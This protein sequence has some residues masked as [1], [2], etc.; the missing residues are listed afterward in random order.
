MDLQRQRVIS[1]IAADQAACGP[2]GTTIGLDS[3]IDGSD[4]APGDLVDLVTEHLVW[5]GS[6]QERAIAMYQ[7]ITCA[8]DAAR[9]RLEPEGD[10]IEELSLQRLLTAAH[11]HWERMAGA[12]GAEPPRVDEAGSTGCHRLGIPE[13]LERAT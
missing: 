3:T 1:N 13:L 12:S 6:S 2:S 5:C 4:L 9:W 11:D 7:L 8:V 10:P